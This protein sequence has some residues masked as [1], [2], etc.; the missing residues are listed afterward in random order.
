MSKLQKQI[1]NDLELPRGETKVLQ[2]EDKDYEPT[3]TPGAD[4][5]TPPA[6]CLLVFDGFEDDY[7]ID[8]DAWIG[9]IKGLH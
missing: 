3:P 2:A 4:S 8:I 6:L 5:L 1:K 7:N 9:F